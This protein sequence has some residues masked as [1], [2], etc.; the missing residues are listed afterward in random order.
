MAVCPAPV[1]YE[2]AAPANPA[3]YG[4]MGRSTQS[5]SR[6]AKLATPVMKIEF[7]KLGNETAVRLTGILNRLTSAA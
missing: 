5:T 2:S 6:V 4:G 1:A 3:H 7:E